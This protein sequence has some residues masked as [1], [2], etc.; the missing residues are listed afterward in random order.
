MPI[1]GSMFPFTEVLLNGAPS[2]AGVYALFQ[3]AE[4]I[5]YGRAL[6]GNTT[7][8]SRLRD[9]LSGREGVCTQRATHY[10]WEVSGAAAA[11][12]VTLLEEYKRTFGGLPR[13]NSR[14]G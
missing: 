3:G 5:Y 4:L 6:G 2:T 14:V 9:H 7:I 10:A 11:R 13:C 8:Q 12:E 1:T